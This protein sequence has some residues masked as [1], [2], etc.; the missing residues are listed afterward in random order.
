MTRRIPALLLAAA[1]GV[2]AGAVSAQ[3]RG[4]VI[5]PQTPTPPQ[6]L[7]SYPLTTMP[8]LTPSLP[9]LTSPTPVVTPRAALPDGSTPGAGDWRPG[10]TDDEPRAATPVRTPVPPR[11][12]ESGPATTTDV[13]R[14]ERES[15]SR[16]IFGVGLV[17]LGAYWLGRRQAS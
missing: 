10:P 12:T 4:P 2:Q 1:V 9:I 8:T 3:Y 5:I 11:P 17:V 7:T 6:T 16:W 14:P 13:V 15:G